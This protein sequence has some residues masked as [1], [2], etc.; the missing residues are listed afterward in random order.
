MGSLED[1]LAV[2]LGAGG[3]LTVL[4][5]SISV[6]LTQRRAD[7]KIEVRSED[8]RVVTVTVDRAPD[9]AK[10]LTQVLHSEVGDGGSATKPADG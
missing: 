4:A 2:A 1:A 3:A 5:N 7:V 9:A 10:I 6:W 8:G